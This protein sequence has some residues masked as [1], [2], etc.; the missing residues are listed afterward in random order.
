MEK[1]ASIIFKERPQRWGLRGDPY[2][3]DELERAFVTVT[4]PCSKN[5]FI[6]H[7]EAFFEEL[8]KHSFQW[9]GEM[10]EV[11]RYDHGGMSGGL[12]R[13]AFWRE[14]ALP[15]LLNRLKALEM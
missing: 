7:F 1:P 13:M 10:V 9:S 4:L 15:L 12:V 14:E 2:L 11:D 3:W 5:C 6:N 8:T